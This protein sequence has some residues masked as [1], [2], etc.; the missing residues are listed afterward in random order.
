MAT[1]AVFGLFIGLVLLGSMLILWLLTQLFK[2]PQHQF[3]HAA[4][5]ILIS[6]PLSIVATA[7]ERL[8]IGEAILSP[9]LAAGFVAILIGCLALQWL[10][11]YWC[12]RLTAL[13][14]LG[15][16]AAF[17]SISFVY[18]FGASAAIRAGL[19]SPYAAN[20]LACAPTLVG[21]HRVDRCPSCGGK[22]MVREVEPSRDFSFVDPEWQDEG[23]CSDCH[24]PGV[25]AN[26]STEHFS[27][28]KILTASFLSPWRWDL[29][30][31]APPNRRR[32]DDVLYT[33]RVVGLPGEIV[34]VKDGSVFINGEKMSTPEEIAG[35]K[36]VSDFE[37]DTRPMDF[38]DAEE[39][40]RLADDE[41]CLLGDFSAS[42][43]DSRFFGPVKRTDIKSVVTVCYWPPARWRIW[44]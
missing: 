16:F 14:T 1:L 11:F 8:M 23:I 18:S 40:R 19:V 42:S 20:K 34:L 9:I 15:L 31:Y 21:R 30:V 43:M 38:V 35:L 44:R 37:D 7:N 26:P 17:M 12:F 25:G 36:Y 29:V 4:F 6:L 13:K 41:Y 27:A 10:I 33:S 3:R 32:G 24:K 28:D 39:T 5:A 22:L 2:A